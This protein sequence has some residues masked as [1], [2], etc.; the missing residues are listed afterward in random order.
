MARKV[1]T[2]LSPIAPEEF[3]PSQAAA[4]LRRAGFGGAPEQ[5]DALAQFGPERA[6]D[7][8]VNFAQIP[9]PSPTS[10]DLF[11]GELVREPTEADRHALAQARARRDENALAQLRLEREQMERR[12]R[13]QIVDVQRWWLKRMIESPRPLEEK[14]TLFWHGHFATSQRKVENSY[15]MFAQNRAF[16]THALGSFSDLLRAMIRDPAMLAWLDNHTS[17]AQSPNENLARE[18]MELF[19]LG[20]GEYSES[21]IKEGARALTGYSFENNEF[22]FR[23]AWHDNNLKAI[24]GSRGR[25]TGD[26]FVELILRKPA[27]ASFVAHKLYRFFVDA[28]APELLDESSPEARA[29][30]AQMTADI[31]RANYDLT[32]ALTRLFLSEYFYDAC[33]RSTHIKSPIDLVI[34]SIRTLRTP[35]RNLG[36]LIDALARMGQDICFPPTVAGWAGGRSWINTATLLTR[37]NTLVYLLTGVTPQSA[38]DGMPPPADSRD[39]DALGA[40]SFLKAPRTPRDLAT[41]SARSLLA[42][43]SPS[44]TDHLTVWAAAHFEVDAGAPLPRRI[45]QDDAVALL[46]ALTALPEFQLC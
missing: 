18:I 36:V 25:F 7:L 40:L 30:V 42:V 11:D 6:V 46:I 16:R 13:A 22:V 29:V 24:L 9:D 37:Q 20:P 15:H 8:L 12:D 44:A 2:N 14:M 39:Y 32:P 38:R 10:T 19:A 26:D 23:D 35:T 3:G 27:C 28:D 1:T 43:E 21:D 17:F 41:A 31:R 5:A 33:A 4:L 34:G 45:T